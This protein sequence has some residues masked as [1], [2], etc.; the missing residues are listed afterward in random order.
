V[1]W[2]KAGTCP[3][4]TMSAAAKEGTGIGAGGAGGRALLFCFFEL[5]G[6]DMNEGEMGCVAG[7]WDPPPGPLFGPRA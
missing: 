1:A 6:A 5:L 2:L 4:W 7:S 3:T